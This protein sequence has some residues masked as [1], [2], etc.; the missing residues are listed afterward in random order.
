VAKQRVV[1]LAGGNPQIAMAD[2]D[3][4]VRQYLA[5]MPGWKRAIGKRVDALVV[6][7]VPARQAPPPRN[8]YV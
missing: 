8:T 3:K 1:L 7:T 2:G 5:A 6:R 4:P